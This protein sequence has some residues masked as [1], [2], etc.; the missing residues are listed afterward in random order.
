MFSSTGFST[1]KNSYVMC[2]MLRFFRALLLVVL[3]CRDA[4]CWLTAQWRLWHALVKP[5]GVGRQGCSAFA[6]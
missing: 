4:R 5:D 3:K 2:I 1:C 6:S